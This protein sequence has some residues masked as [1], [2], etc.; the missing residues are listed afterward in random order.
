MSAAFTGSVTLNVPARMSHEHNT[1]LSY[2]LHH[3]IDLVYG[4]STVLELHAGYFG[5]AVRQIRSIV[6]DSRAAQPQ[7]SPAERLQNL[8]HSYLYVK[9]FL[10]RSRRGARPTETTERSLQSSAVRER[11]ELN[12]R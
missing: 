2:D 8:G 11:L 10:L 9:A 6:C 12:Q 7:A 3:S 4:S 1:G 5:K